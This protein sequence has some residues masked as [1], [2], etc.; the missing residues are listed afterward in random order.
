[1]MKHI[2]LQL[3]LYPLINSKSIYFCTISD[4]DGM[5]NSSYFTYNR[6]KNNKIKILKN[7]SVVP[8]QL[9]SLRYINGKAYTT[10]DTT[11]NIYK[12][13]KGKISLYDKFNNFRKSEAIFK[14]GLYLYIYNYTKDKNISRI[15][16]LV[17]YDYKKKQVAS[18][19]DI[20]FFL[21]L[22]L[23]NN[24]YTRVD[25]NAIDVHK[26][27]YYI[28]PRFFLAGRKIVN[29]NII[30]V[31]GFEE[32]KIHEFS[33]PLPTDYGVTDMQIYKGKIYFVASSE[34]TTSIGK[35]F[36]SII[37]IT[38]LK[39]NLQTKYISYDDNSKYEGIAIEKRSR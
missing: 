9:S 37:F 1:M 23:T 28:V 33:P 39:G 20:S 15:Y 18:V 14:S 8:N 32:T 2:L 30:L 24:R 19:F 10:D 25:I 29:S 7:I 3:L 5:T 16:N 34:K 31:C 26:N 11:G 27:Q 4:N 21:N 35:E 13:Y 17:K 12:I 22:Y 6:L 36:K 38:D